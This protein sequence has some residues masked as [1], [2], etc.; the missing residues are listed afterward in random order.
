MLKIPINIE[1]KI[2]SKLMI[3]WDGIGAARVFEYDENAILMEKILGNYSLTTMSI[4]NLDDD[5][6]QIICNVANLLHSCKKEPFPE[7][8]PL[9]VWFKDLFLFA[10]NNGEVFQKCA[11][12]GRNLLEN[13][14]DI[15]VLHGDLHH[16]NIL[17]SSDRDWLAID[18]KG[19]IGERAFDYVN[20][21][22]NPTEEIALKKGRLTDQINVISKE[23]KIDFTHLLKWTAAWA[24]LSAVWFIN[25]GVKTNIAFK[26]AK[27][28]LNEINNR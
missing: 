6:T 15:T 19:L 7:L 25:D 4:N 3:W 10:K 20:I 24:A 23:A 1:E 22:C 9:K 27:I 17:Y 28:A 2:G 8:V 16:G 13:Q 14:H 21:L 26:V 11:N 5:S 12:I 18:P